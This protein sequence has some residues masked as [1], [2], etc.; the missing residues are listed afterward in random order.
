MGGS[1]KAALEVV[2]AML[3]A[4]KEEGW[5][6]PPPPPPPCGVGGRPSASDTPPSSCS[7]NSSSCGGETNAI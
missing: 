4:W 6:G 7:R 3:E 1:D 2:W 5:E